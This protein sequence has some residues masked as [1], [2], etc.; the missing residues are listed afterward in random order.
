MFVQQD[1]IDTAE[2]HP[3]DP[4]TDQSETEIRRKE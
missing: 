3:V 2:R 4:M 1:P